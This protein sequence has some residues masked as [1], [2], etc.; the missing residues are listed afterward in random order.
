MANYA[1]QKRFFEQDPPR[2]ATRL[3]RNPKYLRN[4]QTKLAF[5]AEALATCDSVLEIGVG[6]GLQ[7]G[8]LLD[9]LPETTRYAGVDVAERPL[10]EA[11]QALEVSQRKRVMLATA[12]AEALPFADGS[13]DGVFCLDVLHH[14]WSQARMLA[15]AGRVLRPGG[16]V[17]CVE[18]NPI[19]PVNLIYLGN[20][21]ERKLFELTWSNARAW[22]EVAGLCD[23][24]LTHL[25]VF[26]PGFPASLAG[27]Y[28][29]CERVLG[30]VP[31][32]RRMST[33]R[34]LRARK[35]HVS[36]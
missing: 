24:E 32:L 35:P 30:S 12:G 18:P 13:F 22:A 23:L 9:R 10:R 33:T 28:Q 34:V 8:F 19:Y 36:V 17:V 16:E 6:R 2:V 3:F 14:V 25:P 7:L 20:V 31:L 26:F 4:V 5:V 21:I 11:G 1:L 15:E 27:V 29:R